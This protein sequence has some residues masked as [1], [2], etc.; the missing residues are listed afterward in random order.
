MCIRDRPCPFDAPALARVLT[1][2]GPRA[3]AS[4]CPFSWASPRAKKEPFAAWTE[5]AAM[6][7]IVPRP[8]GPTP[9]GRELAL[10]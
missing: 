9:G 6:G 4:A 5:L 2:P 3:P 10:R 8:S 7:A 1:R